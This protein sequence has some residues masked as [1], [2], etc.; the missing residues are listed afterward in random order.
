MYFKSVDVTNTV[1]PLRQINTAISNLYLCQWQKNLLKTTRGVNS[2]T[3]E[4][5]LL[6]RHNDGRKNPLTCIDNQLLTKPS[7]KDVTKA[8]LQTSAH[9]HFKM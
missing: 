3:Q 4:N 7:L 6:N 1:I 5:R 9:R 8:I 2:V